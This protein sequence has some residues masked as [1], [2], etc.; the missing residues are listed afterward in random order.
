MV[1]CISQARISSKKKGTNQLG[2]VPVAE[3]TQFEDPSAAELDPGSRFIIPGFEIF[4]PSGYPGTYLAYFFSRK[5]ANF[6][7]SNFFQKSWPSFL[8]FFFHNPVPRL[9]FFRGRG[10]LTVKIQKSRKAVVWWRTRDSLSHVSQW[11]V[12]Q[13]N[14][15]VSEISLLFSIL[16]V[17]K[18]QF[19][20]T[21]TS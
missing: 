15:G 1:D 21:S 8:A 2:N 19:R 7:G 4:L 9:S 5:L 11:S 14:Q 18:K 16:M 20:T 3:S 10:S 12:S 17:E 13:Q 6:F